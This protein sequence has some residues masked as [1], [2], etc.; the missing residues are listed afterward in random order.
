MPRMGS[1][2]SKAAILG[3]TRKGRSGRHKAVTP[4][5]LSCAYHYLR[6]VDQRDLRIVQAAMEV[7]KV[8]SERH[9]TRI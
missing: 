3:R 4:L 6:Q 5:L 1:E 7:G 9:S 8:F 2:R